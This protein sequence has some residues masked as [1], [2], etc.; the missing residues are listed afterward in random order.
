MNVKDF[1][2]W[3]DA[4]LIK[5]FK[6]SI[7]VDNTEDWID[8]KTS[9]N[10]KPLKFIVEVTSTKGKTKPICTARGTL[11]IYSHIDTAFGD[12]LSIDSSA[13][14]LTINIQ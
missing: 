2:N 3:S 7:L 4:G 6:I 12:I 11:K 13:D 8:G 5:S 10:N 14:N 1:R 9:N